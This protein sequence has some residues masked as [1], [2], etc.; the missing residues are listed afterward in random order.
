MLGR[1]DPVGAGGVA[2][3]SLPWH[4]WLSAGSS[5]AALARSPGLCL[6]WGACST[7]GQSPGGGAAT[8]RSTQMR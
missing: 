3:L 8:G 6:A 2:G 1:E 4:S 7:P 5:Q